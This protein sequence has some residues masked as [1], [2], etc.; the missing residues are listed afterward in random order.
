[1]RITIGVPP[2]NQGNVLIVTLLTCML[3]GFGLAS[4]L[5]LVS[6]QNHSVMRSLAWNATLPMLEAGFE[7]GLTQ[8]HYHGITNLSANGWVLVASPY[9]PA[10]YRKRH[11]DTSYYEVFILPTEPP[12][13][14]SFGYVEKPLAPAAQ[15]GVILGALFTQL[16]ADQ[17]RYLR[18]GARVETKK[19]PLFAKAMV[20][21]G[22]IDLKGRN[23]MTDSFDSTRSDLSTNGKYDP[24]KTSDKG[25]VA[26]NSSLTNSLNI[27]NAD[28][29]GRVATGPRGTVAIGPN[30]SVGDSAWV[31]SNRKGIQP[32]WS[33]DD[34]SVDFKE[35]T[36]PSDSGAITPVGGTDADG[37]VYDYVLEGG[38]NYEISS[39]QG[40]VLVTGDA[41]I[42]VTDWME[43]TGQDV[44]V[45]Q[46][47][48][49]LQLYV[50]APEA[51]IGGQ[52]VLNQDGSAL[53]FQYLGLPENQTLNYQGN[54]EF[55]GVVYAPDTD[56]YLGGGGNSVY[57]FT[58]A[59]ITKTVQ[60][61]GHYKFH[62][63]EALSKLGPI[64][65]Y[66]VTSWNEI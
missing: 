4:Y 47:G 38:Q 41:V 26:T 61:N 57:D 56:F 7:E 14:Y 24:A 16:D 44:I 18:R 37:N 13:L 17:T 25:D 32:G 33:T 60:M 43:F 65:D 46:P 39:F 55:I 15:V 28:I 66:I 64:R 51:L 34:M 31:D 58:G 21:E 23:I 20:A 8:V 12:V 53:A 10:Y 52:G 19:D 29:K 9:G 36:P 45:I 40:K 63:D 5:V 11:L 3:I 50:S 48:A 1:M 35:V 27:G 6:T 54:G 22:Q 62:Y 59:S 42:H 30:G 49:S 2:R